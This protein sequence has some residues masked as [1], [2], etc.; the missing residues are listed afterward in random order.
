MLDKT[1]LSF[2]QCLAHEADNSVIALAM[3]YQMGISGSDCD[4]LS[5]DW[6]AFVAS[7]PQ[8]HQC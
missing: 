8:V 1:K 6:T 2:H 7:V 3:S 4:S 5:R